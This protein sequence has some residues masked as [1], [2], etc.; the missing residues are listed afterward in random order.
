MHT[1]TFFLVERVT[2]HS[3]VLCMVQ[4]VSGCKVFASSICASIW[5]LDVIAEHS[6]LFF[7]TSLILANGLKVRASTT[8]IAVFERNKSLKDLNSRITMCVK[9]DPDTVR[10]AGGNA[11]RRCRLE[12]QLAVAWARIWKQPRE[13][14]GLS[15]WSGCG[16]H[17][18][19]NGSCYDERMLGWMTTNAFWE[20]WIPH[21]SVHR[22]EFSLVSQ[23]SRWLFMVGTRP[24][25]HHHEHLQ[26]PIVANVPWLVPNLLSGNTR[27]CDQWAF[28][29]CV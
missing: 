15:P 16:P 9:P 10:G 20:L 25:S 22:S 29:H 3:C 23:I 13:S 27:A 7:P 21:S 6:S 4:D 17:S 11:P 8:S 12:A 19:Q 28:G 18:A 24:N 14:A 5:F 1:R 2:L 26:S